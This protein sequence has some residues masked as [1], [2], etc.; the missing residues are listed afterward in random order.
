MKMKKLALL[1]AVVMMFAFA[2]C[3]SNQNEIE[4]NQEK[5]LHSSD[6]YSAE[7]FVEYANEYEGILDGEGQQTY[8]FDLRSKDEYDNGHIIG[9]VNTEFTAEDAESFIEKIPSDWTV[10]VIGDEDEAKTM[11]ESLKKI[12]DKLFVY[13]VE[14][15]YDALEQADGIEQYIT[16]KAGEWKDFTRTGAEEK[17]NEVMDKT[18]E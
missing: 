14:G 15:G 12:D 17:L 13:I 11:R 2:G 5:F 18:E 8:V 9:S 6:T 16:Q 1:L 4:S 7:L 10:F 3:T